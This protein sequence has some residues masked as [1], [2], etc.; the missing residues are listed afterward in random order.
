MAKNQKLFEEMSFNSAPMMVLAPPRLASSPIKTNDFLKKL[1]PKYRFNLQSSMQPN[2]FA[3]FV[4]KLAGC[5]VELNSAPASTGD[6]ILVSLGLIGMSVAA[7]RFGYDILMF[8]RGA[9]GIRFPIVVGG[10]LFYAW[11][12]SGGMYNIIRHTQFA[13]TRKD[14]SVNYINGDARDQ[15]AA[16]G[17][18]L[19]A[20]NLAVAVMI[21]LMNSR[22]YGT[23]EVVDVKNPKKLSPFQHLKNAIAPYFSPAICLGVGM[24]LWAQIIGIYTRLVTTT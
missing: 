23:T 1:P 8:L 15:Y 13:E 21:V 12:I 16:E 20:L 10:W 18:I 6:L 11:C 5:H 24:A 2:D 9:E 22:A 3:S 7:W 14:G 17:M 4:N 19:G